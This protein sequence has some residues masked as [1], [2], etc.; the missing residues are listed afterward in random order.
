MFRTGRFSEGMDA[1]TGAM[2]C[3]RTGRRTKDGVAARITGSSPVMTWEGEIENAFVDA[4][5]RGKARQGLEGRRRRWR[6]GWLG[7]EIDVWRGI[8]AL[9]RSDYFGMAGGNGARLARNPGKPFGM[10]LVLAEGMMWW[11]IGG[12]RRENQ[13]TLQQ[14]T[15]Y[16]F[17]NLICSAN[18]P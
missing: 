10:R 14:A 2:L 18:D 3:L 17:P 6:R 1:G 13:R 12:C 4:A 16:D 5:L 7:D 9:G 8:M 11:S 15:G